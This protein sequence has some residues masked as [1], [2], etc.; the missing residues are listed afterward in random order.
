MQLDAAVQAM[1]D[2]GV[3]G[4]KPYVHS[5]CGGD[6]VWHG[7]V[8]H[9]RWTAQCVLGTIVRFQ[10]ADHRPWH[11]GPHD[12]VTV[13]ATEDT[14][15][16]YLQMRYRLVPS[17]V[18]AG[19]QVTQHAFPLAARLDMFW[20]E[21]APFSS[22]NMSYLFLNDTLVAPIVDMVRN[23]STRAVWIPPGDWIDG[24]NGSVVTGPRLATVT[25]PYDRIP[26]WHRRGSFTVITSRPELRVARQDWSELTLEI[27]PDATDAADGGRPSIQRHQKQVYE[28]DST[29]RTVLDMLTTDGSQL[30][31][32]ISAHPEQLARG[33]CLRVHLRPGQRVLAAEVDGRP[34]TFADL[35]SDLSSHMVAPNVIVHLTP[36]LESAAHFPFGGVGTLPHAG[37]GP[38]AEL[39][40]KCASTARV[41]TMVIG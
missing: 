14:I 13:A 40:I 12:N 3:H 11:D 16:R 1:V 6:G 24:W 2:S 19:H 15:R 35:S 28:R 4:L 31:M 10:G 37:S 7:D 20:P 18:A 23:V 30:T 33:W 41:V 29:T 34:A 36:A 38:V 9:V 5:D 21:H 32:H 26:M 39:T 17:L 25:Q 22:D 8:A 27:F